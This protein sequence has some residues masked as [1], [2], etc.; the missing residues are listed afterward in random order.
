MN[1][2]YQ[3]SMDI[4]HMAK[5]LINYVFTYLDLFLVMDNYTLLYQES[6]L[7]IHLV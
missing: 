6:D 5:R 1:K 3:Q 7:L 4:F 2:R